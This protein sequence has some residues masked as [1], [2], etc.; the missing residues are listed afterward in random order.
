MNYKP[1]RP[2]DIWKILKAARKDMK[3][4]FI[5]KPSQSNP[6]RYIGEVY[7]AR[8][9][10]MQCVFVEGDGSSLGDT[11]CVGRFY[12]QVQADLFAGLLSLGEDDEP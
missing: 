1:F 7:T 9:N 3:E 2:G 4:D 11:V 12:T 6:G 8:E 10:G 5:G